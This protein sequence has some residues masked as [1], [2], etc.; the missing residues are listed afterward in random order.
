MKAWL[1]ILLFLATPT[2]ASMQVRRGPMYVSAAPF[3][4]DSIRNGSDDCDGADFGVATCSDYGCSG[5]TLTCTGA[6]V[7]TLGSCTG[8]ANL[9]NETFNNVTSYDANFNSD[10][11]WTETVSDGVID[12]NETAQCPSGTGFSGECL[13]STASAANK[14]ALTENALA[15]PHDDAVYVVIYFS[16]HNMTAWADAAEQV[17]VEGRAAAGES[18]SLGT[19]AFGAKLVYDADG[20]T[21]TRDNC[22]GPSAC[23]RIDMR[24]GGEGSTASDGLPQIV[25]DTIYRLEFTVDKGAAVGEAKLGAATIV[26]GIDSASTFQYLRLGQWEFSLAAETILFD[27]VTAATGGYVVAP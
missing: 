22:S 3:C 19:A 25:P 2:M 20:I 18:A 23:W 11:D 12:P 5:G 26:S 6:C 9:L 17:I 1:A 4:G 10:G 8:C 27:W 13:E 24:V 15:I 21:A 16:I 7:I 14:K